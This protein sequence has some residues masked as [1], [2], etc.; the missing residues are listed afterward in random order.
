MPLIEI[1]PGEALDKYSILKIKLSKLDPAT[2]AYKNV[3]HEADLIALTFLDLTCVNNT[4][5]A[6][7][8]LHWIN[9]LLWRVEDKLRN[10][11]REKKFNKYFIQY[12]RLVYHLND[13]RAKWKRFINERL[14]S[15][16]IEEKAYKPY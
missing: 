8:Q 10:Y 16:V 14:G 15:S 3:R 9:K 1:S 2:E 11:E 7:K 13:R 12:A 4:W 6:Y 5:T